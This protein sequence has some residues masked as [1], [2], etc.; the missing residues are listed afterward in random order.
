MFWMMDKYY[1][2]L[3]LPA[4][5]LSVWAQTKVNG[6]FK[7]YSQVHSSRQITGADVA[8]RLLRAYG[9]T[10]VRVERVA[11]N[12]SD[13]F[14]PRAMVIRLSD[15]VYNATSVAAI[16]VAAHET[17]H[18]IQHH[19]GYK[20]IRI[21]N[22]FVPVA[23]IGSMLA[24][25]LVIIGLIASIPSL[26]VAGIILFSAV[27]AFQLVTLPVEFNAS[28]RA[29]RVLDEQGILEQDE[30]K[31]AKKVLSAAAMTYVA[32]AAVAIGNL[33]R[34]VMLTRDRD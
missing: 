17:G 25:P 8:T 11:G 9:I 15:S 30:L 16:G 18:A 7:K 27:V 12:L 4:I 31:G 24:I 34:L 5:I 6:T 14:D 2:I 29:I 20:P 33:L 32:A 10:D 28:R 21:R 22:V 23:N 13:H 3:V 26:S 1:I 19:L